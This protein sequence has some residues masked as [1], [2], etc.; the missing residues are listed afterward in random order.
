MESRHVSGARVTLARS[1]VGAALGARAVGCNA[2]PAPGAPVPASLGW[3][4]T[5]R[6][7][8]VAQ[9]SNE[10]LEEADAARAARGPRFPR[11]A[12]AMEADP[13]SRDQLFPRSQRRIP[14]ADP[15]SSKPRI[16]W[17]GIGGWALF[18][19]A[20][21]VSLLFRPDRVSFELDPIQQRALVSDVRPIAGPMPTTEWLLPAHGQEVTS[22]AP[23]TAPDLDASPA[24]QGT[25]A[26]L[27]AD[28]Q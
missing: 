17:L 5:N 14:T 10:G 22:T 28:L 23:A 1:T 16:R 12:A 27:E 24:D 11:F 6:S 9:S 4:A 13:T 2:G 19:A 26:G 18:C 8:Q 15:V 3:P 25:R 20:L 7:A 21:F